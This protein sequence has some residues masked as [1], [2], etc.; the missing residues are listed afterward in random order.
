VVTEVL[1]LALCYA[2]DVAAGDTAAR[3]FRA[4]GK[5]IADVAGPHPFAGWQTAFD[6]LLAP[7]ARNSWKSH[8]FLGRR[9]GC[10]TCCWG[11][12]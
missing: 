9:T 2:G 1:V 8:D 12:S 7:G 11:R 3:P 6:P 10:S 5:P 4:I